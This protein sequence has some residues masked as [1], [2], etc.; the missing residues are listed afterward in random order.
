MQHRLKPVHQPERL[1]MDSWKLL[2][3]V[4]LLLGAC[5][6]LGG[7]CSKLRQS[8]L[9]GY[10]LAGMLL[11]GPGSVHVIEAESHI[12][13]IAELGVALLLFSLGL[14]FSWKRLA[15]LGR[16]SLLSGAAQVITSVLAGLLIGMLL[17]RS[18]KE[19]VVIGSMVGLSSTAAVLRVLVE[20]GEIDSSYGRNALAILLVQD[21]A[22]VPLAILVTLLSEGGTPGE[23]AVSVTRILGLA[24]GLIAALYLLLNYVAV[25]ALHA[26]SIEQNRELTLLLAVVVGLGATWSAHAAGLSPALGA[27]VA[28]MFLGGSPFATQIRADVS[29]LRV[30]LLTLFFGA[31][32]MVADPAWI[33]G[34][35][36]IVLGVAGLILVLKS[37]LVWAVLRAFGQ[38][39]GTALATGLCLSQVGE[40]AFVLGSSAKSGGVISDNLSSLLVSSSIVTLFLTPY[41]VQFAPRAA[42]WIERLRS[43]PSTRRAGVADEAQHPEI[44]IIGFGPAGQAVGRELAGLSRR[45]LVLDLNPAAKSTAEAM[46]LRGEIG[47]A[48][49]LDVLEHCHVGAAEMVVI[50]LPARTAALTVLENV[51]SLAPTAVIIVRSRYQLHQPDFSAAGA[52]IVIG[53]EQEVGSGLCDQVRQQLAAWAESRSAKEAVDSATL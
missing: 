7:I 10:L 31:V 22:V 12:D 1:G 34:H 39:D 35:V 53:D 29:S 25:R 2:L 48:G 38:P 19:S 17:G 20:R 50:T 41:L 52:D 28:G 6:A 44:V 37:A 46:G 26:L 5:L 23:V 27:F 24:L 4:V 21:V 42:L 9:V 15:G 30:V 40:F 11:G 14:E 51:R 33:I 18:P 49:S 47:D 36:P 45:V 8:P 13:S 3:E 16:H 43:G 32:G